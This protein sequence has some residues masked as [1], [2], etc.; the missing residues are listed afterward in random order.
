MNGIEPACASVIVLSYNTKALI[1]ACLESVL[2]EADRWTG[3]VETIVV[4]NGSSDGSPAAVRERF[5]SVTLIETGENL[6]FGRGNNR[7]IRESRGDPVIL[8][9]SDTVLAPGF[10]SKVEKE[11]ARDA[12]E[13]IIGPKLLDPD[14]TLQPSAYHNFPDPI[15]EIFGYTP[16]G[17]GLRGLFPALA[18]PFRYAFTPGEHERRSEAAHVKGACLILR[19]A[20]LEEIG[21]FDEDFFLYR[22]ETDLC[23]RARDAGWKTVYTPGIEIVHHHKASA[24]GFSDRGLGHRLTSHALYLRKHHGR[25]G[26]LSG[27]ILFFL[28]AVA[29]W[30]GAAAAALAGRP[31]ARARRAYFGAIIEWHRRHPARCLGAGGRR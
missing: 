2:A 15:V 26:A 14:G 29:G 20:M 11:Q 10:F 31:E 27:A 28:Y 21:G 13:G 4:D 8:L 19:R 12:R 30:T 3:A 17:E 7:G 23:R 6:G 1:L 16:I 18:W 9:N 24:G 25:L 5:P 22:E